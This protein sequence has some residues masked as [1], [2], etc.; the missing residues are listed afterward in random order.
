M[1]YIFHC[2][3][4]WEITMWFWSSGV[5]NWALKFWSLIALGVVDT[6]DHEVVPRPCKI[7]D[8]LLNSSWDHFGLH[9]R[10]NVKVTM[11]FNVPKSHI[12]R[13]T[14]STDMVQQ[15]LRWERQKENA[16]VEK[17][18]GL[19]QR[20]T[21]II[22]KFMNNFLT[23][24]K[25]KTREWSNLNFSKTALLKHT[26][27]KISTFTFLVHDYSSWTTFDLHLVRGPKI[28][29]SILL[30]LGAWKR[31]IFLDPTSW[32]KVWTGP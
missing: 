16:M 31:A 15:A 21:A 3:I 24:E 4:G 13:P 10:Q 27:K 26:F 30:K 2:N 8:W 18:R 7:C 22:K 17:G 25:M 19:W 29:E 32:S 28:C 12:L 6:M 23:D 14:L 1:L 11:E 9:P 20:R 5:S